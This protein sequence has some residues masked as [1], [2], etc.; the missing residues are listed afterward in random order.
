MKGSELLNDWKNHLQS[1]YDWREADNIATEC[2]C[3]LTGI[4]QKHQLQEAEISNDFSYELSRLLKG[5][6]WQYVC[7]KAYF[8]DLIFKVSPSVLIPRPETEEMVHLILAQ[9]AANYPYKILDLGTGSGCIPISLA[10]NRPQWKISAIDIDENALDIAR[11]NAMSNNVQIDFAK[12]NVLE[13]HSL[14]DRD[15][16]IIVSNPPY[17]PNKEKEIMHSNVLD[18]EPHLA[19]FVPDEDPL[20]FY[21]AIVKYAEVHLVKGGSLYFEIN[22]FLAPETKQLI[23]EQCFENIKIIKDLSGKNRMLSAVKS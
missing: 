9:H 4:T 16:D 15:W 10:K 17:I 7:E 3:L 6:P 19:L 8:Y 5:E 14:P 1:L 20:K 11:E 12:G 18:F 22:E 23:D 13:I 2:L 21:R